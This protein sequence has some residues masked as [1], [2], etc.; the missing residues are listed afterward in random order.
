MISTVVGDVIITDEDKDQR[1]SC[2]LDNSRVVPFDVN[3]T[4]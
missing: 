1:H 2:D 3:F 4:F